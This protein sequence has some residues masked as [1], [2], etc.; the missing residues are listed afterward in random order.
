MRKSGIYIIKNIMS[1]KMYIGKSVNLSS[2]VNKHFYNLKKQKH[3][4]SHLQK[5]YNKYG[6]KAFI[7]GIIEECPKEELDIQE[8]YWIHYYNTFYNGYNQ[9]IPNGHNNGREWTDKQR[10]TQSL[11]IKESYNRM[12][13]SVK[14]KK[15]QKRR[16][17]IQQL[18]FDGIWVNNND[19]ST[20]RKQLK[21]YDIKTKELI[22]TAIS[23]KD[24][25]S[26]INTTTKQLS[27]NLDYI[28]NGRKKKGKNGNMYTWYPKQYK[29]YYFIKEGESIDL[30]I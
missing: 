5:S 18:K 16:E 27:K 23:I 19:Y 25:A 12:P 9:E 15:V 21:L 17:T 11:I 26:F 7:F 28:R 30:H 20:L 24:A 8:R 6:E 22:Y 4:N 13:Q 1:D 10:E 14:D 3:H 2:R 29:G